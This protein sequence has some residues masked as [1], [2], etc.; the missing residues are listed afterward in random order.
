MYRYSE[1]ACKGNK[2]LC[3]LHVLKLK[4]RNIYEYLTNR[5]LFLCLFVA[6]FVDIDISA[7]LFSGVVEEAELGAHE[8]ASPVEAE[9]IVLRADLRPVG[10]VEAVGE[11]GAVGSTH[12]AHACA[13]TRTEVGID[14]KIY[15]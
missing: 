2:I 13:L 8:E 4:S 14:A 9:A 10:A 5:S 15:L 12:A 3:N 11:V 1:K 6:E 7:C